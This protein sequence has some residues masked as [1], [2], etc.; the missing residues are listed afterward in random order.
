MGGNA[1]ANCKDCVDRAGDKCLCSWVTATARALIDG[2]CYV[3]PP[4]SLDYGLVGDCKLAVIKAA[5]GIQALGDEELLERLEDLYLQGVKAGYEAGLRQR[6]A[7][8]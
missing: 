8:K 7:E 6:G 4:V 1:D 2:T 5:L 3:A